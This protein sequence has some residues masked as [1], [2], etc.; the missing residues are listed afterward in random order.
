MTAHSLSP[1]KNYILFSTSNP[2]AIQRIPWPEDDE[3]DSADEGAEDR[4]IQIGYETWVF[5]E[6]EFEWFVEHD[7]MC[8]PPAVYRLTPPTSCPFFSNCIEDHIL[9]DNRHRDLDNVRRTSLLR[10]PARDG[11]REQRLRVHSER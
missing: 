9:A 6:E 11:A 5:N 1:R 8:V 4:R 7:G 10:G 2:P 3:V